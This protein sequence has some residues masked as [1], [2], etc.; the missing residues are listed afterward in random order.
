MNGLSLRDP[1]VIGTLALT[2]LCL[3]GV[4]VY[5]ITRKRPSAEEVERQRRDYLVGI[6]R[7]IDGTLLDISELGPSESGRPAGMQ[8][9]LYKYEIGGVMY[10]CSQ[11]VT[12]LSDLIDIHKCQ[13]G[14]PCSVRYDTHKPEN[15]IVVAETW[16][17]LR[18]TASS[19]P[20]RRAVTNPPQVVTN[21]RQ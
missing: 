20:I 5:Y 11:D 16:S 21:P 4:A 17:G 7:I 3:G 15:S 6:G 1:Q 2:S 14:L 9:I 19:V 8:L 10:E 12:L 13:L 18:N